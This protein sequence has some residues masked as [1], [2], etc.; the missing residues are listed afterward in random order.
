MKLTPSLFDENALKVKGQ[1]DVV[2]VRES[3]F[4]FLSLSEQECL[5]EA[6]KQYGK[7]SFGQLTAKSHDA[8]W[9]SAD[10]NDF[11]SVEN[12]AASLPDNEDLL[13]H[14]TVLSDTIKFLNF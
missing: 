6:I 5:D 2:P 1:Y 4:D 9:E 8:A 12:I 10:D 11:I 14:L 3:N 7:L 13:A